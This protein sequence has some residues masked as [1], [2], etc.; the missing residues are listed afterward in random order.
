MARVYLYGLVGRHVKRGKEVFYG[1][2]SYKTKKEA[3][4]EAEA[5]RSMGRLARVVP[6]N[7]GAYFVLLVSQKSHKKGRN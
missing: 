7:G 6:Q 2:K 4:K 1:Y 5:A 3:Q